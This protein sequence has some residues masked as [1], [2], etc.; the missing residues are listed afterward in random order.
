MDPMSSVT[1]STLFRNYVKSGTHIA[2]QASVCVFIK[3]LHLFC[4]LND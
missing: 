4:F 3:H 1:F 2:E